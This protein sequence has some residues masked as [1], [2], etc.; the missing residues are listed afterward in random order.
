ML[1][2]KIREY[3]EY[4][5][6]LLS[7][8]TKELKVKYK[9]S[10]LGFLWSFV[11]PLLL[12][13]VYTFI[14]SVVF[15]NKG[16]DNFPIFL[17]V[18]LL[19]WNFMSLSVG[20]SVSSIVSN[21]NLIKKV[22]FPR[23]F[24]PVSSVLAN[25]VNFLLELMVLFVFLLIFGYRFYYYLPFLVLAILLQTL[26]VIGF[27]L[28]FSSTNVYFR[29][30]QQLI[31]LLLLLWFFVTPIVYQLEMV[32][33][34]LRAIIKLNPMA[35]IILLYRSALY[36]NEMPSALIV[37]AAVLSALVV[38]TIGYAIFIRLSASFAKEV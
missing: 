1:L 18:G 2:E 32:P 30:I 19:P 22:Y 9:N 25:L 8:V 12:M 17:L 34:K 6:L 26:V 28:F 5:E 20:A 16:I 10:V 29:D 11:N 15:K 33:A 4:R 23:E 13:A 27:S 31:N 14:F 38:F 35:P 37:G 7:L 21:A 3:L 36:K 24:L